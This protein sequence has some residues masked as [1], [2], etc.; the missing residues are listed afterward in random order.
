MNEILT[1]QDYKD[2]KLYSEFT[3][4]LAKD[5]KNIIDNNKAKINSYEFV[6][7]S[8]GLKGGNPKIEDLKRRVYDLLREIEQYEQ[9][10]INPN[11]YPYPEKKTKMSIGYYPE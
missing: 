9:E 5:M 6:M 10:D 8:K 1:D 2:L 7:K 11:E 4:D 3:Q